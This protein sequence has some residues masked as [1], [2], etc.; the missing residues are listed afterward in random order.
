MSALARR[1]YRVGMN[2]VLALVIS[3]GTAAAV[4]VVLGSVASDFGMPAEVVCI[5]ALSV[6]GL[7]SLAVVG[8]SLPKRR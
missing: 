4:A 7:L 6:A 8:S 2:R 3:L 5:N 1:S